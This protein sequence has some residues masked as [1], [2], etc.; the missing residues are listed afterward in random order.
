MS[1]VFSDFS[2]RLDGLTVSRVWRGYGSAIFLEF[3]SLTPRP[4]RRD[5]S[6][7]GPQGEMTLMIQW[8][9]RVEG[10]RTILG[11]SW[12]EDSR[13]PRLFR[14]LDGALVRSVGL[15]GRLP[16]IEVVFSSQIRLLSFQTTSG[17]PQWTLFDRSGE[18][19]R[20]CHTRLG[21]VEQEM[22]I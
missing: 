14:L 2:N 4:V 16:E 21:R 22:N 11:G 17:D 18:K 8:S 10:R 20:W 5:G 19:T 6:Q 3:G 12:S 13:W 9:W 15:Y 1:N 7:G